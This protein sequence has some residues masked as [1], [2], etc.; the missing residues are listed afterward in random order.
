MERGKPCG[1]HNFLY[2]TSGFLEFAPSCKENGSQGS[3]SKKEW[4]TF[5]CEKTSKAMDFSGRS[6]FGGFPNPM[7]VRTIMG[8]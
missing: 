5:F 2:A 8:T 1:R 7:D 6:H 3:H 4:T